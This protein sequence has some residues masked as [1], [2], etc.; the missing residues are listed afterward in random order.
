MNGMRL[1]AARAAAVIAA[2]LATTAVLAGGAKEKVI[3]VPGFAD[4]LAVDG[5]TVWATNKGRVERWSRRGKRAEVA[6]AHPCGAMTV[7]FGSLW[8]ADCDERTINRIDLKTARKTAT[9]AT[10]IANPKGELNV[11]AGAGSIWVASDDKGVIV[12][13][14]PVSDRVIAS[15]PVDPG[16]YYLSF[17][18][19][20]LWAVSAVG[21]SL[22]K[23]DP[24]TDAVVHRTMLGRAPGFLV[25]G[26]GAVWV[27]EQDDGTV[28]RIDPATGEVSGRVTVDP[29]LKYG[30]IDA[31]GGKIWLRTT[32]EQTFVVIDPATLAIR[33]RVGKA[34]GS[35]ALR[36]TDAGVWTS[37]HD[38]HTLSWWRRPAKIG[39]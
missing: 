39:Q 27:Q 37:S 29:S 3:R 8:V 36:Y 26:E 31:G 25:A 16:T 28:A 34:T 1:S 20:S 12:R 17:G 6:M 9:I 14:D 7:A 4:F 2:C 22:Q 23:I 30:D 24:A 15:I 18:F 11:T 32:A 33:A 35:G 21:Q 10:G 19:G 13:I 38:V 5:S